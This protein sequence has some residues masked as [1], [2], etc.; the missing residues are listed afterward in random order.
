MGS[1]NRSHFEAVLLEELKTT[2][3]RFKG[4]VAS[5]NKLKFKYEKKIVAELFFEHLARVDAYVLG[6]M[7]Y[8]GQIFECASNFT[9]P[10]KSNLFNE[11]CFSFI[12]SGEHYKRFGREAGGAIKTPEPH[13]A[14]EVCAQ[15]VAVLEEFYIPRILACITP[16]ERT[17]DDVLS[18][19]DEYAYPAVF[20]HC[21]V[22]I[23][24]L[25]IDKAC[26]NEALA[27]KKVVKNKAYDTSLLADLE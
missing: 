23:G 7:V 25:A 5:K 13:V 9:P 4:V 3:M 16:S 8:G 24:E 27:S 12:S 15:I 1:E 26:I 14:K 17:V 21:A 18:D 20:I 6:G 22:K 10:Y 11:S 2:A 19:P